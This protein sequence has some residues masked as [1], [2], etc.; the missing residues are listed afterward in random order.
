MFHRP[1][2]E[3]RNV[4]RTYRLCETQ[5]EAFGLLSPG[6]LLRCLCVLAHIS[7]SSSK[8]APQ[9][10]RPSSEVKEVIRECDSVAEVAAS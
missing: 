1:V 2:E 5:N 8:R 9:S 4:V 10:L 7:R 3:T 6:F